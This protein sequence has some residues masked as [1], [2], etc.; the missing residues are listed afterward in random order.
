MPSDKSP[1]KKNKNKLIKEYY[2]FLFPF[3]SRCILFF[4]VQ[5]IQFP[6]KQN[7]VM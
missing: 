5:H 3:L 2:N 6:L 4:A 7:A 1:G